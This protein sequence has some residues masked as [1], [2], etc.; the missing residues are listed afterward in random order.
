MLKDQVNYSASIIWEG[1]LQGRRAR[2]VNNLKSTVE[3]YLFTNS[4]AAEE[5]D[6]CEKILHRV[7]SAYV[8]SNEK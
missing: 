7:S 8:D 3:R 4:T 6:F 1:I 5:F 2:D